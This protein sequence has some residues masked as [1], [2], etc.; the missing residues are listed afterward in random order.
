MLRHLWKALDFKMSEVFQVD[1]F[2][3]LAGGGFALFLALEHPNLLLGAVSVSAGLVG[4]IIGAV[5]AG[6]SVQ[7]A[8]FD[9]AFLRKLRAINRDP[10]RYVAPF[11]FTATLGIFAMLGLLCMA[12]MTPS[13][14]PIILAIVG[15]LTA[16]LTFWTIASLLPCLSVLVQFIWLKVDALDVPDDIATRGTV[17]RLGQPGAR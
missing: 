1:L 11:L 6:V 9:Q 2:I 12:A 4:V 16:L 10:V 3:G 13:I 15:S 8:F 5:V 14:N 17:A 7:A